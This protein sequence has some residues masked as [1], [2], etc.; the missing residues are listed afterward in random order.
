[1]K[2]MNVELPMLATETF[3][4]P[5]IIKMPA[6]EGV[7]YSVPAP[8]D[9][10]STAAKAFRNSFQK[11]FGEEPGIT[12][13]AAF[14]AIKLLV[15]AIKTSGNDGAK[16][17]AYLD[18][19]HGYDGASGEISF[20]KNGDVIKPFLFKVAKGGTGINVS[21]KPFVPRADSTK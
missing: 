19:V 16:I 18:G 17:Q 9:T 14:D 11:K 21:D 7:V 1:M 4:D 12:A 6:A 15:A 2:Q 20:D 5:A 3:E 10:A 13:D 8:A